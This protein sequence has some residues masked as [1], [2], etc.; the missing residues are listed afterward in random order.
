MPTEPLI[1]CLKS[2]WQIVNVWRDDDSG[3]ILIQQRCYTSQG[4]LGFVLPVSDP[5][6]PYT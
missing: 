3:H 6:L 5:T 4:H 1:E 2:A